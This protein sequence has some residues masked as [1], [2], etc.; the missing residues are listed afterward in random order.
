[1]PTANLSIRTPRKR[2]VNRSAWL[3]ATALFGYS[4]VGST[5]SLLQLDSRVLSVPFR[6]AVC[7]FSVWVLLTSGQ[8][9]TDWLQKIMLLIWFLYIIR[10]LHDWL[11]S[12]IEGADYALEFFVATCLL[13]ALALMKANAYQNRRFA[14][15]GLIVASTG[16]MAAS[17]AGKFGNAN[18][19]DVAEAS[20]RLSLAAID[21]I[22]LGSVAASA[23]L[24]ATASWRN[25]RFRLRFILVVM[26]PLLL[27]CL[28]LTGSKGP[29]LCLIFSLSM[30]AFRRGSALKF[31]IL[32]FPMLIWLMVASENPLASRLSVSG[33]DESTVDRIVILNDSLEQIAA[34]PFFGSAFVEL[35]S[36]SYPH[37]LFVESALAFGIPIALVFSGLLICGAYRAWKALNSDFDLLGMLYFQALLGA[38]FSGAIYGAELLWVTLALL[39]AAATSVR[40]SRHRQPNANMALPV[41]G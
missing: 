19:Q 3:F 28:V 2:T 21:P 9:R 10:L 37:N 4:I 38:V 23:I 31:G 13:P 7:L 15:I 29:A 16:A 32:A 36:G 12:S 11:L 40:E 18:V 8:R 22:T 25:A 6:I 30:W 33:E 14:M 26:V 17:L 34:A 20:G 39:P 1:M 27:W 5:I 35:N 41:P 24:C